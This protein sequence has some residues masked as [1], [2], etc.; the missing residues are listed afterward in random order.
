[1]EQRESAREL[2]NGMELDA[3]QVTHLAARLV[4]IKEQENLSGSRDCPV[5]EELLEKRTRELEQEPDI[6]QAGKSLLAPKHRRFLTKLTESKLDP[7]RFIAGTLFSAYQ[8]RNPDKVLQ[9]KAE[10]PKQFKE[11]GQKQA[12]G[13]SP[14]LQ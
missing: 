14:I 2:S 8:K 13:G 11:E 10:E 3:R 5:D 7:E 12:E 1:M 9:P 6:Q 4:A